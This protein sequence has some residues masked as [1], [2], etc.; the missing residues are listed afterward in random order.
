MQSSASGRLLSRATRL[1]N[2]NSPI[3]IIMV[4]A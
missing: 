3:A 2:I 4:K 1:P